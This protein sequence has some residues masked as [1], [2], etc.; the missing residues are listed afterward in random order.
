LIYLSLDGK[1]MAVAGAGAPLLTAGLPKPMFQVHVTQ[2]SHSEDAS[3]VFGWDV[4][5]DGKRLLIDTAT[6][7]S[8][9]ITVVL[10]WTARWKKE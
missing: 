8:E 1:L 7:S 5:A 3:Q 4:T 9:P 10:N 6:A 2:I